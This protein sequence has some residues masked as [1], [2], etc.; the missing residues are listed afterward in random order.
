VTAPGGDSLT[1]DL[2][3]A[4]VVAL[5]QG[6]APSAPPAAL[7]NA[8]DTAQLLGLPAL[9]RALAAF[10]TAAASLEAAEIERR[11]ERLKNLAAECAHAVSL[12]P[13]RDAARELDGWSP[14]A[15]ADAEPGAAAAVPTLT[16]AEV[17]EDLKFADAAS[18]ERARKVRVSAPVAA[19]LRAALDWLEQ[20]GSAPRPVRLY[21]HE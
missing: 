1:R 17:L 12:E 6:L 19:A 4:L 7:R 16:L 8:I 3:R 14:S 15:V 10:P 9:E 5:E 13:F 2:V 21:A 20:D 18:A 11:S